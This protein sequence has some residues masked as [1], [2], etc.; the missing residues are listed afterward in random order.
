M[1]SLPSKQGRVINMAQL[2][3]KLREAIDEL[4]S[5]RAQ[6][7]PLT[8]REDELKEILRSLGNGVHKGHKFYAVIEERERSGFDTKALKAG[9][10]ESVWHPYWQTNPYTLISIKA[11]TVHIAPKHALAGIREHNNLQLDNAIQK[12]HNL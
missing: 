7:K 4:A 6:I 12:N 3:A 9:V 5:I 10:S 2:K 1:Q 8:K 11:A